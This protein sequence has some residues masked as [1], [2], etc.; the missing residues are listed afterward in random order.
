M[1]NHEGIVKYKPCKKP[2][3][4]EGGAYTGGV[5]LAG[6][7]AVPDD[8]VH[9]WENAETRGALLKQSL[10]LATSL[11]PGHLFVVCAGPLSKPLINA[12]WN[13]HPHHQY[14]DFGSSMDEV[15]KG[16]ITRPYMNPDSPYARGVDPQWFCHRGAAP[17]N[18][19]RPGQVDFSVAGMEGKCHQF[20]IPEGE[21]RR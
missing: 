15:L 8:A 1:A 21:R 6:C 9:T 7:V 17:F 14:I 10:D 2:G 19:S 20:S 5:Y 3:G 18:F 13:A 16:R 11:P 4:A 12:L